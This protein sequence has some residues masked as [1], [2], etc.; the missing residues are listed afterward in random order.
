LFIFH[1]EV[2]KLEGK[3]EEEIKRSGKLRGGERR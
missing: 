3:D 1:L 2:R